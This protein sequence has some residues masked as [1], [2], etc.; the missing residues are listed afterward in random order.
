MGIVKRQ[1]FKNS[2][3][4]YFGIAIALLSTIFVYPRALETYGLSQT[5]ISVAFLLMPFI[6]LGGGSIGVR[7]YPQFKK[8]EKSPGQLLTLLLAMSVVGSLMM[9]IIAW[10]LL[11]LIAP[12]LPDSVDLSFIYDYRFIILGLAIC[13]A[14][15]QVLEKYIANFQRIVVPAIFT[16]LLPK[17]VLPAL[18]WVFAD[19]FIDLD[20]FLFGYLIL[21]TVILVGLFAYLQLLGE[22]KLN[23][24]F[25]KIP[26]KLGLEILRFGSY[27][28]LAA[29]GSVM[30]LRIDVLMVASLIDTESAGV[31]RIAIFAAMVIDVPL[32]ASLSI[33]APMISQHWA[34]N[35]TTEIEEL[36]QRSSLVLVAAGAALSVLIAASILDVFALTQEPV[37][38]ATGYSALLLVCVAKIIDLSVSVSGHIIGFSKYYTFNLYTILVLGLL[39]LVL[40]YLFIDTM[41]LGMTGAGLA[42]LIAILLFSALKVIFIKWRFGIASFSQETFGVLLASGL[43]GVFLFMIPE[44]GSPLLNLFVKSGVGVLAFTSLYYFTSLVP[45]VQDFIK[46]GLN[47]LTTSRK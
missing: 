3:V 43:I 13:T 32:R 5:L 38:L 18:I 15:S 28:L 31:Y 24:W 30:A 23:W 9:P 19:G 34:K 37:L 7:F 33:L 11:K 44:L 14:L 21:Y 17:L 16:S 12:W 45:D 10:Y 35:E 39:N 26:K 36:Y 29:L 1:N 40:N 4:S 42:T 47:W 25:W 46:S 20:Q 27:S 41:D 2:L 22:F 8:S 6:A